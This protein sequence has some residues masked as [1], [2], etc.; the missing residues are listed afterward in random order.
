M[1]VWVHLPEL[2]IHFYHKEVLT[3]LGNLIGRTIKLD[4]H[5]LTQQRAKFARLA[6][7]VDISKPLVPRIWLDD[8]WQ[9]V[10]YENLPVV[11]FECGKIGHASSVCPLLRP[12]PITEI[13]GAAGGEKQDLSPEGTTETNAGFGPWMLVSRKGRRNQRETVN[14]GKQRDSGTLTQAITP[15]NGKN[16]PRSKETREP[17]PNLEQQSSPPPQRSPGQERK[18]N[19]DT[20]NGTDKRKGKGIMREEGTPT[21]KGLLGPGPS[22]GYM[23][24]NGPQPISDFFKAAT[25][26]SPPEAPMNPDSGPSRATKAGP[27]VQGD[28]PKVPFT[29]PSTSVITGPNG[30]VMQVVQVL[31][32][33]ETS[34]RRVDQATPS[35]AS[36]TKGKKSNKG[37]VKKGSPAK[38][39]PVRPLQL[40]S[41]MKEKKSKPRTRMASLTLKEISAWTEAAHSSTKS[42]A[43]KDPAEVAN[44]ERRIGEPIGEPSPP[45]V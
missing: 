6:V 38:L 44:L 4:Y 15:K 16:G 11:C 22:L 20:Q 17:F 3:S 35:T 40:W 18:G 14:K 27:Q 26:N 12:A 24:K 32:P 10:E 5:T 25:S 9:P 41:P 43:M 2:K 42:S 37:R 31:P 30:T 13:G 23:T 33:N 34:P 29:P 1:I 7:E 36:R 39:N 8:D 19:G 28:K 45:A 21:G